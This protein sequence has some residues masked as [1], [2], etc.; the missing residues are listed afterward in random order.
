M[1]RQK[2]RGQHRS[3]PDGDLELKGEG[4][5]APIPN[6]EAVSV[7]MA[8]ESLLSSKEVSQ[9]NKLHLRIDSISSRRW[10]TQNKPRGI[11]LRFFFVLRVGAFYFLPFPLF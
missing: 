6:Q 5:Q 8:N 7:V 1:L 4:T 9:G 2:A 11:F 3:A 10:P